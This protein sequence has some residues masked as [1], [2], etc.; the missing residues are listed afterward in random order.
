VILQLTV[1]PTACAGLA[2]GYR[3]WGR[4]YLRQLPSAILAPLGALIRDS[5]GW[6]AYRIEQ[7]RARLRPL[8]AGTLTD[9][10]AE[11]LAGVQPGDH[12]IVYP[13]DQVRDGQRVAARTDPSRNHI[14]SMV[15]HVTQWH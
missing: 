1:P 3:V 10:D 5:G 14:E 9:R 7:G 2:P 11:V 8:R 12:L 4:V 13:S 15:R 6:A